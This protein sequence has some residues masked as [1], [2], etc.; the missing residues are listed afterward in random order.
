METVLEFYREPPNL[1]VAKNH[2]FV[3]LFYFFNHFISYWTIA[4]SRE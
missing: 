3:P 1:Q 2:K 4:E